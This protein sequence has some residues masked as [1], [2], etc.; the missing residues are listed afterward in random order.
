VQPLKEAIQHLQANDT[1]QLNK[2]ILGGFITKWFSFFKCET[3]TFLLE[4]LETHGLWD[5]KKV[6]G[7][8]PAKPDYNGPVAVLTRATVRINKLKYFWQNVAP[9]A[10]QMATAKGF[11]Y[12]AGVGEIPWIKQATFSVWNSKD[13]MKAFAYGMKIHADVIKKTRK[14]NWYSEDMFTRFNI[15]KTFGSIGGS[16][17][18]EDI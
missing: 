7:T 5:G 4:P 17:P 18:M 15:I 12:S 9:V 3:C 2:T 10:S 13:D 14:Q 8:L 6:F 11:I 1:E 16:N